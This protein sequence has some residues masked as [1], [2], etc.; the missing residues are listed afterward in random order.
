MITFKEVSKSFQEDFWKP[1]R[2][3]LDNLSFSLEEGKVTGFLGRNGA[4]KTTSIKIIL[5][6]IR[7]DQGVISF[8]KTLGT[9]QRKIKSNIGYLPERPYFYPDLTGKDYCRYLIELNDKKFRDYKSRFFEL[10]E[11]LKM[12]LAIDQKMKGYSKGMLQRIGFISTVLHDPKLIIMDEPLSG[13]D[14]IGRKELKEAILTEKSRGKT[15]FFSSHI[16]PDLEEVSDNILLIEKGKKIKE[17]KL[18]KMLEGNSTEILFILKYKNVISFDN[19]NSDPHGEYQ[20]LTLPM[21]KK[22]SFLD[23]IKEHNIELISFAPVNPSLEDLVYGA[24]L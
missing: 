5:D 17:D 4:G 21:V 13:L 12:T 18:E 19:F 15:I 16:V 1:K 11:T 9:N 7:P 8:S 20:H 24:H 10:A 6:F 22:T 23:Y 14:P 3:A 2:L